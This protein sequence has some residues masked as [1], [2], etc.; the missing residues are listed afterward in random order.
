MSVILLLCVLAVLEYILNLLFKV[1][2]LSN[3]VLLPVSILLLAKA[4]YIKLNKL[5]AQPTAQTS[6]GTAIG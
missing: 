3:C 1:Y 2:N 4:K 6:N 5:L